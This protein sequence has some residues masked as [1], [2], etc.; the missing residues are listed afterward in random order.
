MII[1]VKKRNSQFNS[2]KGF[3]LVELI[4]V[5]V[6]MVILLSISIGGILAWQDWSKF[7]KEN[8]AAETIFYALQ[9]QLTEFDASGVYDNE[10]KRI[11]NVIDLD[12][13]L[14]AD[15]T[16]K[17]YFD[18]KVFYEERTVNNSTEKEYY[19]WE[20]DGNGGIVIWPNTPVSAGEKKDYQG[21]IYCIFA[22][23][24][25]YDRYLAKDSTLDKGTKFL[26]D[27]ITPYI[28][29]TSILNGAIWAE[30]SLEARQVFSVGYSDKVTEFSYNASSIQTSI[31]D[32]TEKTRRE[33]QVGYYCSEGLSRP[34]EGKDKIRLGDLTLINSNT[35]ELV[36]TE[37]PGKI[38]QDSH[39]IVSIYSSNQKYSSP[40]TDENEIN[41]NHRD[42]MD[43][44]ELLMSMDFTLKDAYSI[45]TL[46]KASEN[47]Q[48]IQCSFF[49]GAFADEKKTIRVPVYVSSDLTEIH[50]VL[51][52][53]D[54]QA[55]SFMCADRDNPE[56]EFI[57]T[58]SF[59]RFGLP[60]SLTEHIGCSISPDGDE[61]NS[62]YS[63]SE[64]PTFDDITSSGVAKE[65][66]ILNG[67]HL[68][69]V[70][71]ET[72]YKEY[73]DTTAKRD[74]VVKKDIDWQEFTGK[75]N[76]TGTN[77]YL[78]SYV[79]GT[80]SGIDFDGLDNSIN[81]ASSINN[82][83]AKDTSSYAFPG[84]RTLGLNDSFYGA[85]NQG[86]RF[87]ISNLHI[88]FAANMRY[89]V[90]GKDAYL[91]WINNDIKDFG[92][93]DGIN[94]YES[95]NIDW[96]NVFRF[97]TDTYAEKHPSHA[98]V[99]KGLYPLGLFAENLGT[100]EN[101]DLNAHKVIGL[102]E[103]TMSDNTTK[104]L[105]YTNMV[106]GFVGNN[107]GQINNVS[108]RNVSDIS[109][110]DKYTN[111][112]ENGSHVN[113]KTDVGGII[114]RQSWNALGATDLTIKNLKNYASVTGME[115]VGGIV[116]RAYL[117]REFSKQNRTGKTNLEVY[118]AR[119][120]LYDDGYDIYGDF[121]E[122]G[123]YRA[124]TSKSITG[125]EVTRLES[126]T[127]D[128]CESYG[129]VCGDNL[130]YSE[131]YIVYL[132][133]N[134][135]EPVS[136]GGTAATKITYC[137]DMSNRTHI[138]SNIG[139]IAGI[140]MDGLYYD[141]R[142]YD[143]TRRASWGA[144][145]KKTDIKLTVK[146]CKAYR[147]Y[148]TTDL[149]DLKSTNKLKDGHIKDMIQHDFY[150]GGLIG[151]CRYTKVIGCANNVTSDYY[152]GNGKPFVFGR[153][154]V[155]GLFGCFD[156]SFLNNLNKD[157]KKAEYNIINTN[158]VIGI[159]YVG[160]FCGGAGIGA[161]KME[162]L[163]F[164][165]PSLNMGTQPSQVEGNTKG[166]NI[167]NVENT[168]VVLGVKKAALDNG[169]DGI[170]SKQDVLIYKQEYSSG[171]KAWQE[172]I[173][174]EFDAGIG[175]IVGISR[176]GFRYVDNIQSPDTK[177]Y[178]LSLMGINASGNDNASIL[179]SLNLNYDTYLT[180]KNSSIYGGNCVGGIM[181]VSISE[182]NIQNGATVSAVVV[183]DDVVGG[184][185]GAGTGG[186]AGVT[187]IN[188]GQVLHSVVM[189]RNMVG[190]YAGINNITL[191]GEITN[192]IK[193]YGQYAV[194]G[195]VGEITDGKSVS[196]D[197]K[198]VAEV[199]AK[200]YA[201]GHTGIYANNQAIT[202]KLKNIKVYSK[203]FSGGFAGA[204]Y[205]NGAIKLDGLNIDE[206]N[207]KAESLA[208]AGGLFGFYN[209]NASR[210]ITQDTRNVDSDLIALIDD[211][212][213]GNKTGTDLYAR[214]ILSIGGANPVLRSNSH[215][216]ATINHYNANSECNSNAQ[217]GPGG[218][219]GLLPKDLKATI[220]CDNATINSIISSSDA[221]SGVDGE[222]DA[223]SYTG[224][225]T[226]KIPGNTTIKNATFG[227]SIISLSTAH[228]GWLAE[229]NSGTMDTCHVSDFSSDKKHVGGLCAL[230]TGT[231]TNC[232]VS[233]NISVSQANEAGT[234]CAINK[235][236]VKDSSTTGGSISATSANY[237]GGIAGKNLGT[238]SSCSNGIAVSGKNA[239]GIAGS[240]ANATFVT[241]SNSAE[242]TGVDTAGGILGV[243]E[244]GPNIFND[245][246]N[247][248]KINASSTAG[249][250]G[251]VSGK[252]DFE[253][254]RN[255]GE[256]QSGYALTN[257]DVS[258][259][260]CTIHNCLQAGGGN[261]DSF[262]MGTSPANMTRNFYY[263]GTTTKLAYSDDPTQYVE[264]N[265][266]SSWSINLKLINDTVVYERG[267]VYC[268]TGIGPVSVNPE[269]AGF[270]R[271][272]LY[273][274]MDSK[275]VAMAKDETNH[276]NSDT[277]GNLNGF[278]KP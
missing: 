8:T 76:S 274:Q 247:I 211:F 201:G 67:R 216:D 150:K 6:I 155:G 29:D 218:L 95:L 270:D 224:G 273:S 53:A 62:K 191:S 9:N 147:I 174:D 22:N 127:I 34:I 143:N 117:I 255:Y 11:I 144:D 221:I 186:N 128:S 73:G 193:V 21:N 18:S 96:D 43:V 120:L 20:P 130:I 248:G 13:Y 23:K 213:A 26:F 219:F 10:N 48:K 49:E 266:N 238:I 111:E 230:N 236:T 139:G 261:G 209:S 42:N 115:N 265:D 141:V 161:C 5:L 54:V 2:Q 71:F 72:D 3:T 166:C 244:N 278:V 52:A 24:D 178:A 156:F 272:K 181:G 85:D 30:F 79:V 28:S 225:I 159:T 16:N 251:S 66:S 205:S 91:E 125:K 47:P 256:I 61:D 107:L 235:G 222:T 50:I 57:N 239:G 217:I 260:E 31:L 170:I 110:D 138:C 88:S 183:G 45:T 149:N 192:P 154:Y 74:F 264:A 172:K 168:G 199:Y 194:G 231:I 240:S 1:M 15:P 103:I 220:D 198:D 269:N 179:S 253:L 82:S 60:S 145:A 122:D 275:F 153:N 227:G 70:R 226:G 206:E 167:L 135:L 80:K 214:I 87:T 202:A 81:K 234:M 25:D 212:E 39:Y 116:G 242:I 151:Y 113:G 164:R 162:N 232:N 46:A 228:F 243:V 185:I 196:V 69:N 249:I 263:L 165:H 78:T 204:A 100:I 267:D 176:L 59:Y 41:K 38:T 36:I 98:K 173:T 90:Y 157:D 137:M 188:K 105:V 257:T 114:G 17:N 37:K 277:D 14:V 203:Y 182:G 163:S 190:G 32:R 252:V 55:Q 44:D 237:V 56:P 89:G 195:V 245:C 177:K 134:D 106:G 271:Q 184:I 35:L 136:N 109:L 99:L 187:S 102:E 112:V 77:Y 64:S 241:C 210:N 104:V 276:P 200:A 171:S 152:N 68:Y 233:A 229:I 58:Y 250:A 146:D 63:N 124:S 75:K 208:Y 19:K 258:S 215:T 118:Q 12:T 4:V 133:E 160:G 101:I 97:D 180:A 86:K 131:K 40:S 51:D 148:E 169:K 93:Y 123:K 121:S 175:G 83:N 108:L 259:L 223:F 126:L 246:V 27:C 33:K 254:C 7:K 92:Q 197:I 132:Y 119:R 268:E 189:G 262:A 129:E 140:T 65:Y 84:F 207:V 142:N 94:T 158:N